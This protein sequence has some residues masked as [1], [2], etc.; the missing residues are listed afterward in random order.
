MLRVLTCSSVRLGV[1][2]LGQSGRVVR[3]YH[4]APSRALAP[5]LVTKQLDASPGVVL[6]C[7]VDVTALNSRGRA[8]FE[9]EVPVRAVKTLLGYPANC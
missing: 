2:H 7:G 3:I 8:L 1:L 5:G 9:S 4:N 6:R